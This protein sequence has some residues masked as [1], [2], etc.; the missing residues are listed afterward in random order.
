MATQLADQLRK[1]AVPQSSAVVPDKTRPSLLFDPREAANFSKEIFYQ[2][3]LDGLHELI[4]LNA[5][6]SQFENSLFSLSSKDFE[7]SVQ[8][9]ERNKTLDKHIR[10]FLLL[11]SPYF[12][13][14]YAH[15]ALEW[16]IYRF[17]IQDYNKEDFL[18][19]ILPYHETNI[20]V[21]AL[22]LIKIHDESDRF[23][24]LKPLQKHGV[25]LTKSVLFNHAATN[26]QFLK[27][28]SKFLTLLMKQ[29]TRPSDVTVG[30][31]FYCVTAIGVIERAPDLN[32]T[33][34]SHMLPVIMKGL[35]SEMPDFT[36]VAYVITAK[37]CQKL[38]LSD[39]ILEYLV[40]KIVKVKSK[41]LHTEAVL[42]L[43]I[44]YQSQNQYRLMNSSALESLATEGW[45]TGN[46]KNI[47]NCAFSIYLGTF[48]GHLLIMFFLYFCLD[49]LQTLNDN[50]SCIE[51]LL[52]AVLVSA[53]KFAVMNDDDDES[54]LWDFLKALIN[55]VKLDKASVVMFIK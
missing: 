51:P 18:M 39:K 27:C 41:S 32:E 21:R 16:L 37:L 43:I 3:G 20:F 23:S 12:L 45:F 25:R 26:V 15:K 30:L 2:I 29:H 52:E 9:E 22:Q 4:Q 36:S 17:G 46:K 54:G 50:G 28:L 13:L 24:W 14:S 53:L 1:L 40:E 5:A 48:F 11:L 44:L 33:H 42:L 49:V 38:Q 34:V 10:K 31:N 19:L 47:M 7:R 8:T 6:F 35:S 55:G